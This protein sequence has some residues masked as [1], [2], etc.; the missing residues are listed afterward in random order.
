MLL[1]LGAMLPHLEAMLAHLGALAN[2]LRAMLAHLPAMLAHLGPILGQ[3][4][5]MLFGLG[6][7]LV[8]GYQAPATEPVSLPEAFG[9]NRRLHARTPPDLFRSTPGR[10]RVE[11]KSKATCIQ[12]FRNGKATKRDF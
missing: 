12:T 8:M 7:G 9:G 6:L 11:R 1:H 4:G 3:L 2:N 10:P 5:A